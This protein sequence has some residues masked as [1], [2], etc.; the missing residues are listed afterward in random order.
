MPHDRRTLFI[1]CI[2]SGIR[3]KDLAYEFERYGQIT[4]VDVPVPRNRSR[5]AFVEFDDARDAEDAFY[6]MQGRP[7][8]DVRLDIQ[9]RRPIYRQETTP[10]PPPSSRTTRRQER[11]SPVRGKLT[12]A[13]PVPSPQR[14]VYGTFNSRDSR[15]AAAAAE[16]GP[17]RESPDRDFGRR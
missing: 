5:F 6:G 10:P 11:Q 14:P 12:D 2:D 7:V 8:G 4:R 3:A 15:Q 13:S 17:W 16:S 9:D 1:P